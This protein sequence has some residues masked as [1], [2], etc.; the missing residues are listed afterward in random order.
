M[1]LGQADWG[2]AAQPQRGGNSLG[3]MVILKKE[4]ARTETIVVGSWRRTFGGLITVHIFS[5]VVVVV[6]REERLS[7]GV[8]NL[9]KGIYRYIY[10]L[11]IGYLE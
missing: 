8:N 9:K 4:N 5:V 2:L 6:R 11:Y 3:E 1:G 7:S 10:I